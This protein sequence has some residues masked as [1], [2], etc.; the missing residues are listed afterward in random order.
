MFKI[1][2]SYN[3]IFITQENYLD[4]QEKISYAYLHIKSVH[5]IYAMNIYATVAHTF[6][7]AINLLPHIHSLFSCK[8]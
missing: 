7:L 6:D 4:F 3:N 2:L 1:C 8:I 5:E